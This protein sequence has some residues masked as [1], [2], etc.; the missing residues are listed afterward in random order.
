MASN[1]LPKGQGHLLREQIVQ[2]VC[3]LLAETGN[4]DSVSIRAVAKRINRTTPAIY[5][6][7]NDR[8][9]LLQ[10]S[11]LAV[12]NEMAVRVSAALACEP[13]FRVR[14]R[15]RAHAYVEFAQEHPEPYR[16]LFMDRRAESL[17]SIDEL[18]ATAGMASLLEDLTTAHQHGRLAFDDIRSV[19]ITLWMSLHGI[20]SLRVAHPS[21]DWPPNLLDLLLDEL[22]EGLI[23]RTTPDQKP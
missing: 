18:L 8:H 4:A 7:F 3:A 11:A 22:A 1:R 13:D 12:F 16:L 20:A 17:L 6:H 14:L 19:G 9:E 15:K 2:A 10:H 5:E 23:P 21:L